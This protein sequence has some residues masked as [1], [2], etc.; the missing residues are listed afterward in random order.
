MSFELEMRTLIRRVFFNGRWC[1]YGPR[2]AVLV[3]FCW[4]LRAGSR[5]Q[6]SRER[7]QHGDPGRQFRYFFRDSFLMT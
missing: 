7:G 5:I 6:L 4:E 1:A 2:I 3:L